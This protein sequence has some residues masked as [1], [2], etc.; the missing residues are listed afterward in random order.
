MQKL[1]VLEIGSQEIEQN[2]TAPENFFICFYVIFD[3]YYQSFIS[4]R[5]TEYW[6]LPPPIFN[7]FPVFFNFLKS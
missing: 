5:G 2:W 3:L 4:G 7:I 6:T 1:V